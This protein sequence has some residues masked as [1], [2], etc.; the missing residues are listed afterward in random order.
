MNGKHTPTPW[1]VGLNGRSIIKEV[2]GLC[3]GY[4]HYMVAVASAHGLVLQDEAKAN[5][6]FI[7]QAVNSYDSNRATIEALVGQLTVARTILK[8][9][10]TH[11][12]KIGHR[13]D[14]DFTRQKIAEIDRALRLARG[15]E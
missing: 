7:V 5:T 15:G 10:A 14:A 4:D 1:S 12:E 6:H 9:Y 3:D 8:G 2:P 11:D 13:E